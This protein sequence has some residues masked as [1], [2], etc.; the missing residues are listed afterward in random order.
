V[1]EWTGDLND[2]CHADWRGIHLHAEKMDRNFWWWAI[3]DS[4]HK[5]LEN[6]NEYQERFKNG[7]KARMAAESA[8]RKYA[9]T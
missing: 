6:S 7:K 2:D 1:I 3:Y 4:N 9:N 5:E 8:A